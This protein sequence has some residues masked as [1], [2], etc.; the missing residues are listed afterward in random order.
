M[1]DIDDGEL[2]N[3]TV[4]ECLRISN[5]QF[6]DY[7]LNNGMQYQTAFYKPGVTNETDFCLQQQFNATLY[8]NTVDNFGPILTFTYGTYEMTS[9]KLDDYVYC[10]FKPIYDPII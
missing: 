3:C 5:R 10:I 9:Y 8:K 2:S 7:I 6:L 4:N 1:I